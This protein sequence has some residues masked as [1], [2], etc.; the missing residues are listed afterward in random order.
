MTKSMQ[1]LPMT[2]EIVSVLW[3]KKCL[4]D[5]AW[6]QQVQSNPAAAIEWANDAQSVA[7]VQNTADT[8]NICVPDYQAMNDGSLSEISEEQMAGVSGGI[9]FLLPLIAVATAAAPAAATYATAA[10]VGTGVAA[11]TGAIGGDGE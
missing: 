4:D 5:K 2:N 1:E 8:L 3:A 6:G 9:F 10:A 7:T 11:A